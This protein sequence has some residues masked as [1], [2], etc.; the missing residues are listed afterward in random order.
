MRRLEETKGNDMG[1]YPNLVDIDAGEYH[2]AA[3]DGR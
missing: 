1:K 3:R 2:K